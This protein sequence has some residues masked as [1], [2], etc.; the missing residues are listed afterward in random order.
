MNELKISTTSKNHL[1]VYLKMPS[2]V[3]VEAFIRTRSYSRK[4]NGSTA[5]I[6]PN[7]RNTSRRRDGG[8]SE[9]EEKADD[10]KL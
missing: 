4:R 5:P 9:E 10:F 2:L 7:V 3:L 1:F 8:I 6:V